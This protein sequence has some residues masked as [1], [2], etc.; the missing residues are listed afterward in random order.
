MAPSLSGGNFTFGSI[1]FLRGCLLPGLL[2]EY[3]LV[4]EIIFSFNF[5]ILLCIYTIDAGVAT[6][7]ADI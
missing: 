4:F 1:F 7:S 6:T 3:V 2:N 5:E